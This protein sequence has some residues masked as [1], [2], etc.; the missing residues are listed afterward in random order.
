MLANLWARFRDP[1]VR[2]LWTFAYL[3]VA[4]LLV[5]AQS[6]DPGNLS[7]AALKASVAG[8]PDSG[9]ALDASGL[10]AGLDLGFQGKLSGS[11][12]QPRAAGDLRLK[13]ADA[14]PFL[15]L[16]GHGLPDLTQALPIDTTAVLGLGDGRL[17]LTGLSGS[18]SGRRLDGEIATQLGQGRPTFSGSLGLDRAH[19]PALASLLLGAP[20]PHGFP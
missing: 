11:L 1:L 9:Y 6:I 17:A 3:F 2:A 13:S 5:T 19:L 14:A 18:V 20:A 8:A 16:I 12:I 15:R 4:T 7:G 10:L